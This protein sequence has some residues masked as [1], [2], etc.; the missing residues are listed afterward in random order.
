MARR[1]LSR[2]D[3][4]TIGFRAARSVGRRGVGSLR[5]AL[6]AVGIGSLIVYGLAGRFE[7]GTPFAVVWTVVALGILLARIIILAQSWRMWAR[8]ERGETTLTFPA[9]AVAHQRRVSGRPMRTVI[10]RDDGL[11]RYVHL[12]FS[13]EPVAR[14]LPAGPVQLDLFGGSKVQGPARLT[15][16]NGDVVW[17]FTSRAGKVVDAGSRARRDTGG[18]GG[19][20]RGVDR[21]LRREYR[22]EDEERRGEDSST[23]DDGWSGGNSWRSDSGWSGS[24]GSGGSGGGSSGVDGSGGS[25]GGSD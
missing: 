1:E 4:G 7:R 3:L 6:V 2:G 9:Q 17:A 10:V 20:I 23:S 11:G 5:V 22:R 8:A 19:E 18:G 15:L 24:S 12:L 16:P 13:E 14:R 25:G 21:V